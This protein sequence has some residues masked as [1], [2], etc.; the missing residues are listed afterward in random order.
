MISIK[1][2]LNRGEDE[3]VL[4]QV[5]CTLLEKIGA[6]AVRGDGSEYEAY[7]N[8]LDHIRDAVANVST[9]E[10]L[11]VTIGSAVQAMADH[12]QRVGK[13]I[14][15]QRSEIQTMVS[16]LTETVVT[17]GGDNTRHAQSV[18]EISARLES[19]VALEDLQE[20]KTRLRQ[21]LQDF[22]EETVKQKS[23]MEGVITTLQHEVERGTATVEAG[24][25]ID[26]ATGLPGQM[27][28]EAAMFDALKAGK[29]VYVATVVV[30]RM[31]SVN[32]RFGY[33][34]GDQVLSA[35]KENIEKQLLPG[36]QMF[37]WSGPAMILLMERAD[38]LE[39]V[40]GQLKRFLDARIEETYSMG[41]R[42]VLLPITMAWSAFKLVSQVS[43]AVRQIQTFIASQSPR[44]FA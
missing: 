39:V 42:A 34:V 44:D 37:R 10:S 17:L 33:Q 21:C 27:A 24:L 41:S 2:F 36:D 12:K 23:Q 19:A 22:R 14:Q 26:P 31:Q 1:R 6:H 11:L 28:A 15:R 5:I 40:R 20:L 18:Q 7:V 3:A 8:N 30:N 35:C 29:R 43:I 9:P 38:T 13:F 4:W 32:A 25:E 16:M